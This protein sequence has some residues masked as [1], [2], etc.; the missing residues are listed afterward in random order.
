MTP[1]FSAA[2]KKILY[3]K[4]PTP[5]YTHD[6][7]YCTFLGTVKSLD[8][9][10]TFTDLY[11]CQKSWPSIGGVGSVIARYS[12]EGGDYASSPVKYITG[13]T[14]QVHQDLVIAKTLAGF[15]DSLT[16]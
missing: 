13:Q 9:E 14:A 4:R 15:A 10:Y 8:N 3:M 12:N 16:P 11:H 1:A 2:F 7:Q 6:C 5:L